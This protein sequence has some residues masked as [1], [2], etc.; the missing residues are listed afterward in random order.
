MR[1]KILLIG[2]VVT[3]AYIAVIAALTWDRLPA[4]LCGELNAIGDF[5][6]GVFGPI[7]FMWLVLGYIQQG[8][9]LKISSKALKKQAKE[10]KFSVDQQKVMVQISTAN[11]KLVQENAEFENAR[12]AASIEPKFS[13]HWV[14]NP[15]AIDKDKLNFRVMNGGYA[16]TCFSAYF[17]DEKIDWLGMYLNGDKITISKPLADISGATSATI[18]FSYLNGLEEP[19]FRRFN[20]AFKVDGE[21]S[22]AEVTPPNGESCEGLPFEQS[23]LVSSVDPTGSALSMKAGA[24]GRALPVADE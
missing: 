11:L 13:M 2:G 3:I 24:L 19:K 17:E 5:L 23:G 9:E 12:L 18:Y 16:V 10:L 7:A 1:N 20:V 4:F 6:A 14:R 21:K 8:R 22:T 15:E